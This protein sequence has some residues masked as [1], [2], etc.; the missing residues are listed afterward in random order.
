MCTYVSLC[1]IPMLFMRSVIENKNFDVRKSDQCYLKTL[2]RLIPQGTKA[3][4][5]IPFKVNDIYMY[6]ATI[7]IK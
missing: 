5:L 4:L 6:I 1:G 7:R 3:K 2:N